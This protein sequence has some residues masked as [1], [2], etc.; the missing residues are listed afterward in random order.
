MES[1]SHWQGVPTC[2]THVR[3]ITT[4]ACPNNRSN[5]NSNSRD[6]SSTDISNNSSITN[7]T[8]SS[9]RRVDLVF[10]IS[11]D[12]DIALVE[13]VLAEEL[14]AHPLV[15]KEPKP[16]IRVGELADSSV[17]LNCRP[18]VKTQDYWSVYWEITRAVKTR[19]DTE[20]ITIPFPQRDVHTHN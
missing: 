1:A 11:Y 10:G 2:F 6:S 7:V 8:G 14:A 17:N 4:N 13:R 20:G 3:S 18:W 5:N 15:L 19:F 12:D 9:E 16:D